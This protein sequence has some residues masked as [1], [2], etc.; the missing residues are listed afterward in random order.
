[1]LGQRQL[2]D[3][4]SQLL[5]WGLVALLVTQLLSQTLGFMHRAAHW[6]MSSGD[7][8]SVALRHLIAP[9]QPSSE[10]ADA[11]DHSSECAHGS[12]WLEQLFGH[13]EDELDCRLMDASSGSDMLFE[14]A[15]HTTYALAAPL[16]I[17]F[18]SVR[19]A[20]S[21]LSPFDVR[22]PPASR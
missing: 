16:F 6:P 3:R 5:S 22:G 18:I 17:A 12:G 11:H 13:H 2:R 14:P 19:A 10:I 8:H 21:A 9:H 20:L 1:M 4:R 15:A 7:A